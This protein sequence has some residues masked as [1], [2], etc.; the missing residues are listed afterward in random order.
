[1]EALVATRDRTGRARFRGSQDAWV[2]KG[3][4]ASEFNAHL[5]ATN[6]D[7]A[8]LDR[9]QFAAQAWDQ[10]TTSHRRRF[11]GR[12]GPAF[13]PLSDRLEGGP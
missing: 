4:V 12:V 13:V 3:S 2:A 1:M 7:C 8:H 6:R 11:G 10:G 5:D 9:Q